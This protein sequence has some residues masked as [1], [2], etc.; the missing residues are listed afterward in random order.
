VLQP[1][2]YQLIYREAAVKESIKTKMVDFTI[3]SGE[4]KHINLK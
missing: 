3:K 1:G 2:K 4:M